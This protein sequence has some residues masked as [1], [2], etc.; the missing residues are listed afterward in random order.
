VL[1]TVNS[2]TIKEHVI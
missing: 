1:Y 2:A